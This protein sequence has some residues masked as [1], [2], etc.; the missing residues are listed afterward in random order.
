MA[1]YDLAREIRRGLS[2]QKLRP[3]QPELPHRQVG[4]S[5][6]RFQQIQ[7]DSALRARTSL[8]LERIE[9]R[10][11]SNRREKINNQVQYDEVQRERGADPRANRDFNNS[12]DIPKDSSFYKTR[13]FFY[14]RNKLIRL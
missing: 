7:N 4:D 8:Q 9:S 1:N 2:V 10:P 6:D 5:L 3:E 14:K 11:P 13:Y 12:Q